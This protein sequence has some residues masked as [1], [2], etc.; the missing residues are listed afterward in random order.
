[1]PAMFHLVAGTARAKSRPSPEGPN[2]PLES[3]EIVI[4]RVV[5]GPGNLPPNWDQVS[6]RHCKI[7]LASKV[8]A[9][10]VLQSHQGGYCT[11]LAALV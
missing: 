1:M 9:L 8:G 5:P 6:G 2:I 7:V 4:G 11:S 3:D 10:L